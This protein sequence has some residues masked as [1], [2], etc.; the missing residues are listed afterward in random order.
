M[1][2]GI[3]YPSRDM[4]WRNTRCPRYGYLST[5]AD[6]AWLCYHR[7]REWMRCCPGVIDITDGEGPLGTLWFLGILGANVQGNLTIPRNGMGRLPKP[8]ASTTSSGGPS[9]N[10]VLG[11]FAN[12]N[13]FVS[14][15]RSS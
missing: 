12:H 7:C 9:E 3:C 10:G 14:D 5:G 8:T 13:P 6:C 15:A 11:G 4:V 1:C 2:V